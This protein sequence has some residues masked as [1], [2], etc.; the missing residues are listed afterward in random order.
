MI[1]I[2]AVLAALAYRAMR[3]DSA[4][5]QRLIDGQPA[6]RAWER[7][8]TTE[9]P[10]R[11]ELTRYA[12]AL[13]SPTDSGAGIGGA[14]E[15]EKSTPHRDPTRDSDVFVPLAQAF[16]TGTLLTA[17]LL[18]V[19]LLGLGLPWQGV[20]KAAGIGWPAVLLA[21]WLWRLGVVDGLLAEIETVTGRDLDHDGNVGKPAH[22]VLLD[23]GRARAAIAEERATTTAD[24]EVAEL[25]KFVDICYSVGC[26]ENAHGVKPN[27]TGR[28]RYLQRRDT[29]LALG[30]AQWKNPERPTAGWQMTAS[31]NK[32]LHI[33]ADHVGA[34]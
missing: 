4:E 18:A 6:R 25:Y 1:G 15:V 5:L 29:L 33:L 19:A 23:P 20:L 28:E 27:T 13:Q 3:S 12:F 9:H 22:A 14:W 32:A 17:L 10:R 24:N 16:V 26:S 30:L 11:R 21:T 7:G 2:G 8:A 31:R 34:L